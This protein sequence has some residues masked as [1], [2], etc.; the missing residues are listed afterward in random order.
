MEGTMGD[1]QV[2]VVTP[3]LNQAGFLR[4][5]LLSVQGQ[6]YPNIE[7]IVVDGGSQDGS[8]DVLEEFEL[9][10]GI[11]WLS[12][13]DLG[14]SH[15][16]NKGLGLARGDIVGWLNADDWYLPGAIERAVRL[17]NEKPMLGWVHG[18]GYAIDRD[19]F[20]LRHRR[21][22]DLQVDDLVLGGMLLVQPTLFFR[23]TILKV[24]GGMAEDI[25]TTMDEDFCLRLA[26][27]S[28]GAYIPEPLAV[29]R[30]HGQSKSTRLATT[31]CGDTLMAVDNFFSRSDL[32]EEIRALEPSAYAQRYAVC[33]NRMFLAGD[34][35]EARKY[36][37]RS[38]MAA[39][40]RIGWGRIALAAVYV[41]AGFRIRW[42]KP[43]LRPRL[44]GW[45]FRLRHRGM[46]LQWEKNQS[47]T[48][49]ATMSNS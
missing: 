17:L 37:R 12:E 41:Q 49:K 27:A 3:S 22:G 23:K 13:P 34:F 35:S 2:T 39:P 28:K 30:L 21:P 47:P 19:G 38:M 45:I 25:H 33:A 8:V 32:S 1:P 24:A 31:F 18:E 48:F 15:A 43:G 16:L 6:N 7:H 40:R 20:V 10:H 5:C 26:L 4:E 36:A 46:R 11:K 9:R 44:S 29:R 42:L 14:Q